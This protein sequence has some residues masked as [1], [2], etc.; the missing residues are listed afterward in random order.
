MPRPA[1]DAALVRSWL[2]CP[3]THPDRFEK[4]ARSGADAES[5]D[6]EDAVAPTAKDAARAGALSWLAAPAGRPR[7]ALPPIERPPHGGRPARS[8]RARRVRCDARLPR[9]A[10]RSRARPRSRSPRRCSR[11]RPD[12]CRSS[13]PHAASR[14]RRGDRR[15]AARR[16][17]SCWAALISPPSSAPS[18][19]GSRSSGRARASCRRRRG[20]R[21]RRRAAPRARR[22][23]RPR[24]RFGRVRRLGFTGKLAIHPRQVT[25]INAA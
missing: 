19:R 9:P 1:A 22:R 11:A 6:L 10:G 3:A 25:A 8:P 15:R 2:F 20:D 17:G 23:R 24:R 16:A 13:R 7:R 5:V 12:S 21:R 14:R 18:S 4:A